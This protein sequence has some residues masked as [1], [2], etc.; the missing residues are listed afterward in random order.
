MVGEHKRKTTQEQKNKEKSEKCFTIKRTIT[1]ILMK[2]VVIK[3]ID[4]NNN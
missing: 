4:Q 2:R 1:A 3:N